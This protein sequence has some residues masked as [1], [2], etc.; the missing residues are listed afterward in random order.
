M[1]LFGFLKNSDKDN[2]KRRY[3]RLETTCEY[4]GELL[5][6]CECDN[7][8]L[9]LEDISMMDLL[10]DEEQEDELLEEQ[11]DEGLSFD[12]FEELDD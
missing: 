2:N 4:C 3:S 6:D 5:E 8:G 1:G 11:E 12:D 10:D 7:N 9:S